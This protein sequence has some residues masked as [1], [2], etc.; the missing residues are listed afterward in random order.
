[1]KNSIV[2]LLFVA[3]CC[4]TAL[5]Q[6][7]V[8]RC[9]N[10]YTNA[11]GAAQRADCKLVEGGNVTV[12]QG[13]APAARRTPAPQQ[14]AAAPVNA[15]RVTEDAQRARDQ[16]ARAILEAEL[17]KSQE[18]LAALQTEYNDG[19]P[20]RTAL[21]LRNPQGYIERVENLRANIART[22]A[23]IESIQREIA[24]LR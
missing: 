20:V 23:D 14:A 21:E 4:T 2:G 7:R 15:P 22:Q 9:G 5:A 18:R 1:M 13:N 16:D 8:Y 10:E 24:R 11:S 6:E 17:R 3:T 19:N 12:I